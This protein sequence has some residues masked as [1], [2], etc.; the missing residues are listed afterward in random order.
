MK[1]MA[2]A[3]HLEIVKAP[4]GRWNDW[5]R[6][7]TRVLPDFAGA[8]L[9]DADLAGANLAKADFSGARLGGA[10]LCGANL[11][12]ARCF[13]TEL[14][15]ADLN[16]ATLVKANLSQADLAGANLNAADLSQA[17]LIKAN[18]S[19]ASLIEARLEGAN[20]GQAS[21]FRANLT[22]AFLRQASFFKA[23]LTEADLGQA[24]LQEANLQEAVL[25]RTNLRS[26]NLTNANLCFATLLRTNLEKA[27]IDNC[28]VCGIS[29]WDVDLTDAQQRDL[30]IMPPQQPVLAVDNLQTAQL[31]GMLLSQEKSRRDIFSISL[32]TVVVMGRFPPERK[33][34]VDVIKA[35]LRRC[36]YSPLVLDFLAP[37]PRDMNE[38]VK[39]LGRM[40]RFI[41]ADLT[42][43]S[44]VAQTLDSVVHY[45]PSVPIQPIVREGGSQ[46]AASR[47]YFKYHWVLPV[48]RFKD[49]DDLAR[50][51]DK[52]VIAP[53]EKKTFEVR[54]K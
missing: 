25:E 34:V 12:R 8:D 4:S 46:A 21:L 20:L 33:P 51:I 38:T 19:G 1:A 5:R 29:L 45:L 28:S 3:A 48:C 37:G 22:R 15:G 52:S 35:A 14:A 32:N 50:R 18:L 16:R 36:E 24:D 7:N 6:K 54:L 31:M 53:V 10:S 27:V 11:T 9:R 49:T 23:D 41:I 39:T 40:S 47:H 43:D 44:R 2:N 30:D 26:A 17:F 13:G 42:D